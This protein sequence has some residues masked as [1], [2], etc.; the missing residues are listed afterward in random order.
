MSRLSHIAA[1]A[2]RLPAAFDA[3]PTRRCIHSILAV[4]ALPRRP[5]PA[6]K[7]R[8]S[9]AAQPAVKQ[10]P[11][12]EA[13]SETGVSRTVAMLGAG[14]MGGAMMQGWLSAGIASTDRMAACVRSEESMLAWDKR[15]V[16]VRVPP[17]ARLCSLQPN[18][19][20]S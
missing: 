6:G 14:N 3:L 7:R 2:A 19:S 12:D 11:D 16:Q 9:A 1:P 10:Q 5:R 8:A 4:P 17:F 13:D 15:G 18:T 20:G